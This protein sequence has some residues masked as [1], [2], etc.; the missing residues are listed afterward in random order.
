MPKYGN[1]PVNKPLKPPPIQVKPKPNMTKLI[2]NRETTGKTNK[3]FKKQALISSLK[4][5]IEDFKKM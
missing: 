4:E 5:V 2:A 3:E 1:L